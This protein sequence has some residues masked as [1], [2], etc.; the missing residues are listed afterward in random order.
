MSAEEIKFI[1]KKT[2]LTGVEA[3]NILKYM[4]SKNIDP[5]AV[6]WETIGQDLYG[7]GDR[8]KG[9]KDLLKR[10]YG[11]EVSFAAELDEFQHQLDNTFFNQ[12]F[13]GGVIPGEPPSLSSL[14]DHH[15]SRSRRS[16]AMDNAKKAVNVF[17]PTDVEGVVKW[18]K[19]PHQFD[20]RGIDYFGK[21]TK[22]TKSKSG[23]LK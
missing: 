3:K 23:R 17:A 13:S 15:K 2:G 8:F 22:K 11:L 14:R 20:I 4:N 1:A 7:Y 12:V 21:K 19:R 10:Y 5:Y 9:V 18:I 6:D 16:I